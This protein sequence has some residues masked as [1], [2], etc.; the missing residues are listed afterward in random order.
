MRKVKVLLLVIMVA[1]C[2][3]SSSFESWFGVV[4]NGGVVEAMTEC[5]II[6]GKLGGWVVVVFQNVGSEKPIF[7][8]YMC[9][10]CNVVVI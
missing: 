10:M 4:D 5:R 8:N 3:G 9:H 6:W 2:C 1:G 7:Y